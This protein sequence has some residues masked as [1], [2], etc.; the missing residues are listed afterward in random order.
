MGVFK[1]RFEPNMLAYMKYRSHVLE[2]PGFE[3][4]YANRVVA[5][6]SDEIV[7]INEKTQCHSDPQ[8]VLIDMA[9]YKITTKNAVVGYILLHSSC[10][11]DT[12]SD[13]IYV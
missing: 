6:V 5:I 9:W 1:R 11:D 7:I 2:Q 8:D 10:F 13:N 12:Q 3:A 4:H